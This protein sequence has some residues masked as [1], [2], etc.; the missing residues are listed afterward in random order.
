MSITNIRAGAS[1]RGALLYQVYGLGKLGTERRKA[2]EHRAVGFISDYGSD[3][4]KAVWAHIRD[5]ERV[6]RSSARRSEAFTLIHS[7]PKEEM[8]PENPED[9][10]RVGEL[11]YEL[12]KRLYPN[13]AVSVVVHNDSRGQNL[14]SHITVTNEDMVTGRAIRSNKLH[15]QVSR[16]NDELMKEHGLTVTEPQADRANQFIYWTG[17]RLAQINHQ[18]EE[19]ELTIPQ[20]KKLI[21]AQEKHEQALQWEESI[22]ESVSEALSS[23]S[24]T[25]FESF[26][27]AMADIGVSVRFKERRG[28]VSA[29]TYGF[30]TEEGKTKAFRGKML[31]PQYTADG[32]KEIFEATKE[33]QEVHNARCEAENSAEDARREREALKDAGSGARQAKTDSERVLHQQLEELNDGGSGTNTG[34][35]RFADRRKSDYEK[36]KRA[37]EES[38]RASRSPQPSL[39]PRR[40]ETRQATYGTRRFSAYQPARTPEPDK[41]YGPEF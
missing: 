34:I 32:L 6:G 36:A 26:K 40:A 8:N 35:K 9:I 16:V 21:R 12:A 1:A 20:R 11:G 25:D 14:H 10:Q 3:P 28:E 4:T 7:F 17:V 38:A 37:S 15:K 30:T 33:Y 13:S 19:E 18:L 24:V 39:Q 29:V 22:R 5:A 27:E 31:G 23:G 2:G 41:D